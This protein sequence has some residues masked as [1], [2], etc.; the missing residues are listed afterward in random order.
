MPVADDTVVH[1]VGA[2][3]AGSEAA[4]QLA[5]RR[6][7]SVV[8]HEMRPNLMT[9]AH[10][11]SNFAELVCSNSFRSSDVNS[12][13]GLMHEELR[14]MGSLI[15]ACAD[16]SRVPAGGALAVDR[17]LFSGKVT[18][19]IVNHPMIHISYEE[20]N[21][22]PDD[23]RHV[24]IATGPL[25]SES[26]AT[27]IQEMTGKEHLS[28]FDAISPVIFADSLNYSTVW[29]QSR[30]DK[31]DTEEDRKAYINCP[32]TEVEYNNFIDALLSARVKEFHEWENTACF[33]GCLPI[34]V[35]ASRGRDTLRY[36][37]MKP[38]GLRNPHANGQRP[39][40][41]VQLRMEN[42]LGNLYNMVG[43]Q[44][45][46]L[47]SEQERVFRM[48]PGLEEASFSRLG[49]IHRNTF[50]DSPA[51]LED[52]FTLA[53]RPGVRFAGQITGVEGYIE[54]TAIGLLV[55]HFTAD[56]ILGIPSSHPDACTATGSLLRHVTVLNHSGKNFQPMNVNFGLFPELDLTVHGRK[57]KKDRG[58]MYSNR[59]LERIVSFPYTL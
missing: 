15:M 24:I 38:V 49:G 27:C 19:C 14:R 28:F 50:I 13:V 56:S 5:E 3:L 2:G 48:I 6:G 44:T 11:T 43:F 4:W 39:Y 41:V 31:G 33:E 40:A 45:K 9:Q 55:A 16:I 18:D 32:L 8:L 20:V 54:S 23:W 57:G 53:S 47:Y 58:I 26:L 51:L 21:K 52:D 59:A 22:I 7:I 10:V 46:M 35:M 17:E 34:E 12:A 36:G 1:V 42:K 25:T 29:M 30:Y 37:P